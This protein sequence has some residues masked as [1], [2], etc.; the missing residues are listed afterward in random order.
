MRAKVRKKVKKGN[1]P[2]DLKHKVA[3]GA[4][5]LAVSLIAQEDFARMMS[6][7]LCKRL[8]VIM[9]RKGMTST[10]EEVFRE[11]P[12]F[13]LEFQIRHVDIV[14]AEEAIR[15]EEADLTVDDDAL[16]FTSLLLKWALRMIGPG[17]KKRL[18]EYL[19]PR[20]IHDIVQ[21]E[22]SSIMGVNFVERGLEADFKI[23]GEADQARYFF[24]TL[25]AV[26]EMMMKKKGINLIEEWRKK[27]EEDLD[28]TGSD[29]SF[30]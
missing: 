25:K 2:E 9:E 29:D 5:H 11:G 14:K 21:T 23:L 26:R 10:V 15:K 3:E 4:A 7:K 19:F 20:A 27:I 24:S 6:A 22:M 18:E 30:L 17:N 12:F 13:A 8:P 28:S 1:L 16:S